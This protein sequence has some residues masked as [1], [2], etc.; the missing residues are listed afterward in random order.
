[1]A[2]APFIKKKICIIDDDA[3]MREIYMLSLQ[4]GGFEVVLA[5]NGEKGLEVI[6]RECPDAILLD[7]QMPVM[8]GF[9]VLERLENDRKLC[10][11]PIVILTNMDSEEHF[12]EVGK[13][14][15]RF[16]V[17]KALTTPQKII[18]ILKEVLH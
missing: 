12:R 10:H 4:K 15:T 17:I 8:D 11:I 3:D 13:F 1:M 6:R 5:E 7:L 2:K 16:Y 18:D 9:E 14:R